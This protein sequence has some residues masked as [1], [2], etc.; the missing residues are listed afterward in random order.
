M[1]DRVE[2]AF[3]GRHSLYSIRNYFIIYFVQY[4]PHWRIFKI[5]RLPSWALPSTGLISVCV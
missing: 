4:L 1:S 2:I 5:V 3:L